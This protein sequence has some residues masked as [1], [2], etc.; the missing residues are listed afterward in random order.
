MDAPELRPMGIGDI[1]DTTF[2]L[3]KTHFSTYISIAL[4][5]YVPFTLMMS[6]YQISTGLGDQSPFSSMQFQQQPG[7]NPIPRWVG[8]SELDLVALQGPTQMAQDFPAPNIPGLIIGGLG[9]FIFAVVF[10]PWCQAAMVHNISAGY[11]GEGLGALDSYK[12]A[13]P[14][15]FRFILSAMLV[16][17][18]STIGCCMLVVPGIIFWL[19]FSLVGPVI[20][21]ENR[22]PIDAMSRSRELMRDN[23]GKAFKLGLVVAILSVFFQLFL[24]AFQSFVPWPHLFLKFFVTNLLGVLLLPIQLAPTILLYYDIRIRKEA[25]DL[26]MLSSAVG[27]R[28]SE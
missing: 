18:V 26:M 16:G 12:R 8:F 22:G 17:L 6:I 13:G 11:L 3:Y 9:T 28:K 4:L 23:L 21:L 27:R 5:A 14:R 7:P 1:L 24:M 20:M 25:F 19:W 10:L 2:R 15:V